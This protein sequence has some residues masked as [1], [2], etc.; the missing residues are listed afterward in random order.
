MNS[1]SGINVNLGFQFLIGI[2]RN[3]EGK[4]GKT[5]AKLVKFQFLIGIKRNFEPRFNRLSFT[6]TPFQFLIGIKRNFKSAR[7]PVKV[8]F[9]GFN[10]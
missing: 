2:K 7:K 10:S 9:P 3:F 1:V 5:E 4:F 6:A 8:V